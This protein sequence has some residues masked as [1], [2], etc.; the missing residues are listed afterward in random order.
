MMIFAN[1]GLWEKLLLIQWGWRSALVPYK[2]CVA[3][4]VVKKLPTTSLCLGTELCKA[5]GKKATAKATGTGGLPG[6]VSEVLL[7]N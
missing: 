5:T 4:F 3:F 6:S 2:T 7:S 1:S